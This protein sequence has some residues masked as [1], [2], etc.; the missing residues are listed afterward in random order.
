MLFFYNGMY[1]Q[2]PYRMTL[3]RERPHVPAW[4]SVGLPEAY[5]AAFSDD[6][7]QLR[8]LEHSFAPLFTAA[9]DVIPLAQRFSVPTDNRTWMAIVNELRSKDLDVLSVSKRATVEN[10]LAQAADAYLWITQ[11]GL[12]WLAH[13]AAHYLGKFDGLTVLLGDPPPLVRD[14]APPEVGQAGRVSIFHKHQLLVIEECYAAGSEPTGDILARAADQHVA[15]RGSAAYVREILAG[16]SKDPRIYQALMDTRISC[17]SFY[18][19]LEAGRAQVAYRHVL[20]DQSGGV[21]LGWCN[22]GGITRLQFHGQTL[23]LVSEEERR[24]TW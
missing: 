13:R 11:V 17:P 20:V 9:Q 3:T 22:L 16:P 10:A 18:A 4:H 21:H 6:L 23:E 8:D 7:Q 24:R 1:A 15:S 2:D 5:Q 12:P 19:A 14:Y